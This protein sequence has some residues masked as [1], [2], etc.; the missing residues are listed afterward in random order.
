MRSCHLPSSRSGVVFLAV[1]ITLFTAPIAKAAPFFNGLGFLPGRSSSTASAVSAD[2]KVVVG[3]S[4]TPGVDSSVRAFR[5]TSTDGMTSIDAK[6]NPISSSGATAVSADGSAIAGTMT[7]FGSS[8]TKSFYWTASTGAVSLDIPIGTSKNMQATAVSPDGSTV[9]GNIFTGTGIVSYGWNME[10]GF[11]LI[12]NFYTSA[13]SAD[14]ST[15]VGSTSY[16]FVPFTTSTVAAYWTESAGIVPLGHITLGAADRAS[17]VSSN[18]SVI[19]GDWVFGVDSFFRWTQP[20]GMVALPS[21]V[22]GPP[23][24]AI[25]AVSGDGLFVVGNNFSLSPLGNL[26]AYWNI[27]NG[28]RG[29]LSDLLSNQYGLSSALEG[30]QLNDATAITPDGRT[31]VGWGMNPAGQTEAWIAHVPEPTSFILGLVTALIACGFALKQ[32]FRANVR[33]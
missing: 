27:S 8:T 31:I 22:P 1:A 30:W 16:A 28:T 25:R 33:N 15:R 3:T 26:A 19:V 32:Q 24:G 6:L 11:E 20:T 17:G 14:G 13:I 10:S 23:I 4:S 7:P 21:A 18:G 2:G 5:W 9:Y 29:A 12:T